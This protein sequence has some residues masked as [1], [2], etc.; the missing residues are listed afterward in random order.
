[1]R[2][3]RVDADALQTRRAR[4]T[5][6]RRATPRRSRRVDV[7][8]RRAREAVVDARRGDGRVERRNS[9]RCY[10]R[11]GARASQGRRSAENR[12]RRSDA[13]RRI[14]THRDARRTVNERDGGRNEREDAARGG[15]RDSG[16]S[17]GDDW[18][19]DGASSRADGGRRARAKTRLERLTTERRCVVARRHR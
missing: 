5:V 10:G 14:A 6:E 18:N 13:S 3:A 15:V 9:V 11:A 4:G 17:S 8:R 2:R 1:M 19:A 7:R 12:S 16:E